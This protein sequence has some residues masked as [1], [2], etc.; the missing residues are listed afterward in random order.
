MSVIVTF[1]FFFY[2]VAPISRHLPQKKDNDIS[3]TELENRDLER[4]R[5]AEV[6][7]RGAA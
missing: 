6:G 4:T 5:E 1:K 2:F 7:Q 3:S